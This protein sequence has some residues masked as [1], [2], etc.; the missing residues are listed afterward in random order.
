M[1][2][3][4]IP[5]VRLRNDEGRDL[6]A[7]LSRRGSSLGQ[8]PKWLSTALCAALVLCGCS[9]NDSHS[10]A[11]NRAGS[12]GRSGGAPSTNGG[13]AT[14]GAA[15]NRGGTAS[16]GAGGNEGAVLVG[17]WTDAPGSCPPG[18]VRADI[19]TLAEMQSAS[20][21]ESN[22]DATCFFVHDGTYVQSGTT[23][24]LYLK[25]GGRA[26]KPITWVGESRDGVVVKG[27]ATFEVGADH[28]VLSNMTFDISELSQSGAYNTI[29][30]L[31]NDVV[32][33]HLTL[34]GD[35]AHGLR[36]GH[37]EVPGPTQT[38]VVID[39]CL[40]E[41]FGHCAADGSLDHGVYLSG[42]NDIQVRNNIVRENSS[43]GI[44]L[45]SHYEDTSQT[46][47]NVLI[48]RNR[49]E[50]NGHGDYQ[51]GIVIDGNKDAQV[52]G[53]IDGVV[54]R[55][56]IFWRN[57]YSGVR[58]VGNAVK[59]V[60][61]ANNTFVENGAASTGK[62]RSELNL[63]GGTPEIVATHNIFV[64][65][66][67]VINS[68]LDSVRIADNVVFPASSSAACVTASREDDPQFADTAGGDFHPR[69]A[70]L[71]SYGCYAP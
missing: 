27:R 18:S 19:R 32:M 25:R 20:R 49:I 47:K 13:A 33:S 52:D 36:G 60:E 55:N 30:V 22:A 64:P 29:T 43:R 63:D 57:R 26:E 1:E 66:R 68:C 34:T 58:F 3:S 46:L 56:N 16:D 2:P 12:G 51:D 5:F 14:G 23:L 8:P 37:I 17:E 4:A 35:C 9:S 28:Q 11:P 10:E 21:G 69:N 48:E 31:A 62:N 45:Y 50:S 24:P 54:I 42:G 67:V 41:K 61:I 65:A 15:D 38:H 71:S 70:A 53:T 40:I 59:G 44:Q 7:H 39:S 6:A